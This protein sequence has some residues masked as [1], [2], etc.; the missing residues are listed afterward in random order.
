[1]NASKKFF[2]EL[3]FD[4]PASIVVFLVAV[5][6]CLGIA[7][8]CKVDPFAGI[9]AGIIGGIVVSLFS[10]SALGVSG[11]AAGLVAIVIS[12]IAELGTY[13]AFLLAVVLAGV[14]QVILGFLRAGT[15]GYFFPS[16]VIK[17][18]LAAIGVIIILKQIPHALGDDKDFEGNESFVQHDGE[19]TF[20]EI[21]KAFTDVFEGLSVNLGPSLIALAG[22]IVL[23]LWEQKFIK[24]QGWALWVQGPL[25]AVIV[26]I[27]LNLVFK[28]N[29]TLE[30]ASEHLV[31]L[32]V[33]DSFASFA[34]VFKTP[35]F[36]GLANPAI[37]TIAFTLA[38][39][40]SIESLLCAEATD[41][42]D[43][44]KRTTDLS[45]ELKAQG[46]GNIVSGLIGGLPIT[47]VVVRS[48]ANIQSG[49]RTRASAFIHG[50]LIL[51]SAIAIPFVLNLIPKASL[52]AI[53]IVVGYKLAK[54]V[55]FKDMYKLGWTQFVPFIITLIAIVL[56]DLLIGIS[57]GL[58]IGF[59]IILR[60][61]FKVPYAILNEKDDA[62]NQLIRVVLSEDVSFLNKS[63]IST[64]LYKL[65]EK[66][67]I[68]IDASN[69]KSIDYDVVDIIEDFGE[70]AKFK[71]INVQFVGLGKD[72]AYSKVKE[73][74]KGVTT[75][76]H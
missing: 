59:F 56:T 33:F 25:V 58:A 40:A 23:I 53:L 21:F 7:L 6:L 14:I 17:G 52:A 37:Y 24:K 75:G 15:I 66:S 45:R 76:G 9:I 73:A 54:P 5:P 51:V 71:E 67:T 1:M 30:I 12:A 4:M 13:E 19:N 57:I 29:P 2:G 47:Q 39:V 27:V 50:I 63:S 42:L 72:H 8:A 36:S 64:M 70:Y 44:F 11:P 61:N 69:T 74:K 65:P 41:K 60:N 48:S 46:I 22:F 16:A 49:G 68:I 18:M 43:P 3:K 20:T 62:G 35:D 28:G 34:A 55:L 26:G 31:A 38:V 32:P 10:N